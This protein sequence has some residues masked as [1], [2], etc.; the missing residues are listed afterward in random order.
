MQNCKN[1][2]AKQTADRI[3]QLYGLH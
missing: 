3:Q 2:I 1:I